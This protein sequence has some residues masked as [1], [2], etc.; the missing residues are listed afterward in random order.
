MKNSEAD[1]RRWLRQAENDLAA[2]RVML[3]EGFFAQTCFLAH[4]VAEKALKSLAYY[5]GDRFVT[6]HSLS[7]LTRSLLNTFPQLS[8]H[9][10]AVGILDQHYVPTRYPNALPGSVPFEVYTRG[11]GEDAVGTASRTVDLAQSVVAPP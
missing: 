11:Q 3:R 1:A 5:R 6:G 2:A 9:T 10:E 8:D 4:Q 7:D